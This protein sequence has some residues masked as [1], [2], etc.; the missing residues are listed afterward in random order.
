MSAGWGIYQNK[1]PQPGARTLAKL[2]FSK[3]YSTPFYKST[4]NI[5]TKHKSSAIVSIEKALKHFTIFHPC[6]FLKDLL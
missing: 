5:L 3:P 4:K 6:N 2:K 1:P